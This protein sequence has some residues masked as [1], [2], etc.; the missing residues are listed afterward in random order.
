MADPPK[1]QL[2][3]T[4]HRSHLIRC[5]AQEKSEMSCLNALDFLFAISCH[6]SREAKLVQKLVSLTTVQAKHAARIL[7][8]AY[9]LN[10]RHK[11]TEVLSTTIHRLTQY[12]MI[13]VSLI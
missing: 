4:E 9:S 1:I 5:A 13:Q 2:E 10:T 11:T 8:V 12:Q 6:R 3:N 7:K